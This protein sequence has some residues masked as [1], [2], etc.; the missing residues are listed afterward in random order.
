MKK[1]WEI[2]GLD[3]F[4]SHV[5]GLSGNASEIMH[6]VYGSDISYSNAKKYLAGIRTHL[7]WKEGNLVNAS[8]APV[9]NK[10]KLK[11]EDGAPGSR[12]AEKLVLLSEGEMQDPFTIKKKMG[13]DP[14]QWDLKSAE[15]DAKSW[16]V[17]MKLRGEDGEDYPNTETNWGYNCMVRVEPKGE[18]VL[19]EDLVRRVCEGLTIPTGKTYAHRNTGLMWEIPLFDVHFGKLA[20]ADETGED[21]YDVGIADQ[22]ARQTI[23]DFLAQGKSYEKILFPIGQDFFHIDNSDNET[24]SGT[25]VDTEG[26]WEKMFDTGV[27]FLVWAVAELRRLGPVECFYVPGNHD[28]VLSFCAV[29]CLAWAYQET[30][31]VDVDLAPSPRKY[32]RFGD[33]L[34]GFSH[35]KEGKSRLSTVMQTEAQDWSD[36]TYHEFHLGDKHHERVWE[37]GGVIF[38]RIPTITSTDSW[39]KEKGFVGAVKRAQAFEWDEHLGVVNIQQSIVK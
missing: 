10:Q 15:F 21:H 29:E 30:E 1:G 16:D 25:R 12:V 13:L 24:T 7:E 3:A 26:R 33:G 2:D 5:A 39:H 14:A 18:A 35:G 34:V 17:T 6:D 32:R 23:E 4:D 31:G 9:H 28:K 20:W 11:F 27:R 36:T 8:S 19:K 37:E 22:R 38:R